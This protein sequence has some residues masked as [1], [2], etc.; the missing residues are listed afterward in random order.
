MEVNEIPIF[1]DIKTALEKV[2]F[3]ILIDFT[4]PSVAKHN[5]ILSL[6][7]GKNVIVGTSGLD[8]NDYEDIEKKQLRIIAR[9]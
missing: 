2:D 8:D 6:E 7:K 1:S 4:S 3:D 5:I 9:F